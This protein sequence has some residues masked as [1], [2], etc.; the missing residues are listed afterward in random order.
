MDLFFIIGLIALC[1]IAIG[2]I[3][4]KRIT[5]NIIKTQGREISELKR[6]IERYKR[7]YGDLKHVKRLVL[8]K[9]ALSSDEIRARIDTISGKAVNNF[10]DLFEEF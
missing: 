6:E 3:G 9:D 8:S 4:Y 10:E 5:E 2:F 7:A 1:F